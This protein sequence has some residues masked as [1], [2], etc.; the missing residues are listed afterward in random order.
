MIFNR[1]Q[2]WQSPWQLYRVNSFSFLC[3]SLHATSVAL[4]YWAADEAA[5]ARTKTVPR[6]VCTLPGVP[7]VRSRAA[8]PLEEC[9]HFRSTPAGPVGGMAEESP[10]SGRIYR[11]GSWLSL[12]NR[13]HSSRLIDLMQLTSLP[14]VTNVETNSGQ[15]SGY[16]AAILS[17]KNDSCLW[18][19][20]TG[21]QFVSSF[22]TSARNNFTFL[23][24]MHKVSTRSMLTEANKLTCRPR[25]HSELANC[26]AVLTLHRPRSSLPLKMAA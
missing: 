18:S 13:S 5:W 22:L 1:M 19:V 9:W 15:K 26:F 23:P 12:T 7:P 10:G 25:W 21:E 6:A 8:L 20:S 17:G 14:H 24:R 11:E 2:S 16:F 4:W 3:Q